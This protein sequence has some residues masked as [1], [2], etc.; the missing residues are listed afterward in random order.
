M[1]VRHL[2]SAGALALG[3]LSVA[4]A[5]LAGPPGHPFERKSVPAP[6]APPAPQARASTCD[7]MMMKGAAAM[8]EQCMAMMSDH[9]EP[10][11]SGSAG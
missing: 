6:T 3:V 5:V 2:L 4:P 9:R 7:C 10:H 1:S 8:R 11:T